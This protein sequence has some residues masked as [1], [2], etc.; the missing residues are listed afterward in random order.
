MYDTLPY[1]YDNWRETNPLETIEEKYLKQE[2]YE[3]YLAEMSDLKNCDIN[4]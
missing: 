4:Y 3:E 2:E 1:W